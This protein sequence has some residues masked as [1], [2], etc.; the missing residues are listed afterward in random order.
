MGFFRSLI[1]KGTGDS[2]KSFSLLV[3]VLIGAW[4][5]LI[6]GF[7]MIWDVVADGTITT[8][9]TELGTFMLCIGGYIAGGGINKAIFDRV[10][11]KQRLEEIAKPKKQRDE[12]EEDTTTDEPGEEEEIVEVEPRKKRSGSREDY[13]ALGL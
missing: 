7:V 2:T 8:N 11:S 9:V 12:E 4:L 13:D 6:I 10:E 1:T 3:S 5:G